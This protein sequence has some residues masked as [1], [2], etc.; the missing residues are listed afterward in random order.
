MLDKTAKT[1]DDI[2]K[3]ARPQPSQ[4]T[5]EQIA[6]RAEQQQREGEINARIRAVIGNYQIQCVSFE[7]LVEQLTGKI[8]SLE[9]EC[10]TLRTS[11]AS[12]MSELTRLRAVDAQRAAAQ[13]E[14][15]SK[16]PVKAS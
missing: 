10:R 2:A 15:D 9:D 14:D 16:T 5:A 7:V 13:H 11:N 1:T 4:P 3:A 12:M 8:A 6:A